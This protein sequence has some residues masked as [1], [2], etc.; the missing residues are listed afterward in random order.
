MA[1]NSFKCFEMCRE[2]GPLEITG[3]IHTDK[4]QCFCQIHI[5]GSYGQNNPSM[6]LVLLT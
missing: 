3:N 2:K 5:L 4:N 1:K 6:A